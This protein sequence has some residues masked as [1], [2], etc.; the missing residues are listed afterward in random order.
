MTNDI[1]IQNFS[2]GVAVVTISGNATFA[3]AA[4][5]HGRL[6]GVRGT[7]FSQVCPKSRSHA[8]ARAPVQT[9]CRNYA[10]RVP[11]AH[12]SGCTVRWSDS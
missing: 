8:L 10:A 6:D 12:G 7:F 4:A 3:N 5:R 1:E 9:H 11:V 2:N